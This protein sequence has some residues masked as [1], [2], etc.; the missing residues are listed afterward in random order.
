MYC[1]LV[2]NLF[3]LFLFPVSSFKFSS[4]LILSK[5][6][7]TCQRYCHKLLEYVRSA[8]DKCC[9]MCAFICAS[10]ECRNAHYFIIHYSFLYKCR[11]LSR[12][13]L[14]VGYFTDSLYSLR[15]DLLGS[16]AMQILLHQD[17]LQEWQ[18]S[19]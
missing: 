1:F 18:N 12:N 6:A 11:T 14:P 7:E 3:L 2:L 15:A 9:A 4:F 17:S 8:R 16:C 5:H 13:R 10:N 19:E